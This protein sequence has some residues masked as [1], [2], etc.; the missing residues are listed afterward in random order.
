MVIHDPVYAAL[1]VLHGLA[2][3]AWFG[4]MFYSLTVL[5]PRLGRYF[6]TAAEREAFLL[7][8]S[9]GARWQVV[10]AMALMALSGVGLLGLREAPAL[11]GLILF[12]AILFG[13]SALLF[14]RISWYWWP[15]RLFA[16]EAELPAI[17]AKFR[18]GA[19]AMLVLV[20]L[21]LALGVVAHR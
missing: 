19:V 1:A 9:H 10:A 20:G 21:N 17:Q 7:T 11:D 15:A 14:W 18:R 5:Q 12:K 4:A 8:V 2:G 6:K 13:L 16:V 3:A